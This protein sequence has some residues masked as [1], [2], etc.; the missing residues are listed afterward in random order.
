M[1]KA[2]ADILRAMRYPDALAEVAD[3]QAGLDAVIRHRP[4]LIL[5]DLHMPA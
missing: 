3:G 4:D 5:L 1:R 2:L